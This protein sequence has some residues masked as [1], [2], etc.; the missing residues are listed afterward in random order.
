MQSFLRTGNIWSGAEHWKIAS[1]GGA[2]PGL[3]WQEWG[4][5]EEEISQRRSS[6]APRKAAR[7]QLDAWTV[8]GEA[9]WSGVASAVRTVNTRQEKM[10]VLYWDRH[11]IQV[12]EGAWQVGPGTKR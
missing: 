8:G 5:N 9:E 1:S 3:R 11:A 6:T 12:D 10:A 7:M 2:R 4:G